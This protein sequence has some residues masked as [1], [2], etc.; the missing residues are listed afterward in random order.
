MR[1]KLK[2]PVHLDGMF[3]LIFAGD[4]KRFETGK[5]VSFE[6]DGDHNH[7]VL[8]RGRI[9]DVWVGKVGRAPAA[10]LEICHDPL[11]RSYSG[12]AVGICGMFSVEDAQPDAII[13]VV[14]V[15]EKKRGAIV[16]PELEII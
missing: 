15:R 13:T 2:N 9:V 8:G 1:I 7:K 3:S 12:L 6:H 5:D 14:V 11:M 10:L 16:T 4:D